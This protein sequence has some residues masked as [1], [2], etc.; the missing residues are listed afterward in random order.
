M[1]KLIKGVSDLA[2]WCKENNRILLIDEWDYEKNF[3]ISPSDVTHGT[4]KK[5]WWKC[6]KHNHIW[7]MEISNRTSGKQNCPYCSGR[8]VLIGFNDLQ[9]Q[10][11]SL[12][13]EWHPTLNG[14][15]TPSQV[16][17]RSGKRIWWCCKNGH[18]W[19]TSVSHRVLEKTGCPYCSGKRLLKGFNDLA[20]KYPEIAAEWNYDRNNGLSPTEIIYGSAKNVWWKCRK[21]HEW[22]ASLNTRTGKLKTGCPVCSPHTSFPEQAILFY[23]SKYFSDVSYHNRAC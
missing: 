15:L 22:K 11:P 17:C 12:A 7:Q 9:S 6:K 14:G 13:L 18:S 3:P 19:G 21:G 4:N 5:V 1:G 16:T 23:L 2:T 10:Y 8:K 20:T